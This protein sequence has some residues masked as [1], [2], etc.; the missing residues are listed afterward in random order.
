MSGV[1]QIL[2]F[3]FLQFFTPTA[4]EHAIYLSTLEIEIV[5]SNAKVQI[6][7]FEDDLRDVLRSHFNEIIDTTSNDFGAQI[8]EYFNA[9]VQLM[10]GSLETSLELIT[11]NLVGDTYQISLLGSW[12]ASPSKLKINCDY[13]LELF[14]LQ[15]NIMHLTSGE[16][17]KYFIFKKGQD[18]FSTDLIH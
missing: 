7:V 15:Q 14:P 8:Q 13:F 11:Y 10:S 5:E 12:T 2:C 1:L 6:K 9:H 3:C 4:E 16:K 18:D 17:K